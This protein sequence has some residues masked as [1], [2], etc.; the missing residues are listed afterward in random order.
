MRNH[1]WKALVVAFVCFSVWVL[2]L[3]VLAADRGSKRGQ[4]EQRFEQL[5]ANSM[6]LQR[7]GKIRNDSINVGTKKVK[8][9]VGKF[10]IDPSP[11]LTPSAPPYQL[12]IKIWA[13]LVEGPDE[14]KYVNLVKHKWQR[15]E[16]FK[17]WFDSAVP[18]QL[19]IFQNYQGGLIPTRQVVPDERYP[20]S[21]QTIFPGQPFEFPL[22]FHMDDNLERELMSIVVARTDVEHLPLNNQGGDSTAGGGP[23]EAGNGNTS[24]PGGSMKL[25]RTKEV[26]AKFN[27]DALE[28]GRSEGQPTKFDIDGPPENKPPVSS[29]PDDVSFLLL[30]AGKIGEVQLD[31]HKD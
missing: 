10:N 24:G 8:I 12:G 13:Q 30:G 9:A 26:F 15:K 22:V 21:F 18:V 28:N 16:R 2:L 20:T 17:L 6:R 7:E 27:K 11:G 1:F 5:K 31:L 19:A 3:P 29:T 23:S 25:S 4:F 14:G